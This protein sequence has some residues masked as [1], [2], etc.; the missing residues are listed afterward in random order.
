MIPGTKVRL[1]RFGRRGTVVDD[2]PPYSDLIGVRWE[3][4]NIITFEPESVLRV[5]VKHP[6]VQP[7]SENI[8]DCAVKSTSSKGIHAG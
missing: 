7:R 2:N 4:S 1:G 6:L 5:Q 8:V 3:R